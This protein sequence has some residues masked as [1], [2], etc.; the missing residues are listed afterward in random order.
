MFVQIF[1]VRECL[2]VK[3]KFIMLRE[4]DREYLKSLSPEERFTGYLLGS[5]QG[6]DAECTYRL[7][8]CYT[9]GEFVKRDE[10]VAFTLYYKAYDYAVLNAEEL[11]IAESCLRLGKCYLAGI[12]IDENIDF[13]LARIEKAERLFDKYKSDEAI[14][15]K[16]LEISELYD[17][18]DEV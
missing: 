7:G 3:V 15:H 10:N 14:A 17:K 2:V 18:Y 12:G 1:G 9:D 5:V 8:D 16:L 6:Q 11:D 4:E 13:G